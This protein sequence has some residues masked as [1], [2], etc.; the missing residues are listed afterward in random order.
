MYKILSNYLSVN[1]IVMI[2]IVVAFVIT[3]LA[4][5]RP[6]PFL[7]SDKGRDYALNGNLSK[8]KIRGVGLTFVVCFL[9]CSYIFLPVDREYVIYSILL[10][11]V[12]LSGYLDDASDT[13]WNEYKKGLIDLILSVITILTFMDFNSTTIYIGTAELIIPKVLYIILGIILFWVAINVTN[14]SDGV[15]GLCASVASVVL[16]SFSIIFSQTLGKYAMANFLFVAVLL[17]YLYFNS[18]PSSM[19]MGDAGSRALGFFIAIITIKT[20]HPFI[21]ILLAGVFLIDGGLGLV[22]VFL[23]RFLKIGIL[24]KTLTPI[25]DHVRKKHHWSDTQV[26]V[27]FLII[28]TFFSIL[29]YVILI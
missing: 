23:L 21:F 20:G 22:K 13:P 3:F 12:M 5:K 1:H 24:K 29:A 16:I 15:D 2:G 4:L 11:G 17:A 19:L 18:S 7:P 25:H 8:G 28:Q 26:V 10:F 14:C 27:R 6:L 9:I